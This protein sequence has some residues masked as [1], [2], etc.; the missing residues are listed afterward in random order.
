MVPSAPAEASVAP[1][2]EKAAPYTHSWCPGSVRSFP[3]AD[4]SRTRTPE[5]VPRTTRSP[6]GVKAMRPTSGMDHRDR[7][8]RAD[9]S[10]TRAHQ[11]LPAVSSDLPSGEKAIVMTPYG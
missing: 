3:P 8:L 7:S 4:G 6:D 5:E 1:S 10:Q 2:G 11:S 9:R